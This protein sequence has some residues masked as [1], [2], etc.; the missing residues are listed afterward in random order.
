MTG[1]RAVL[2]HGTLDEGASFRGV[3]RH[4]G[5]WETTA[6]DRSGWGATPG[7]GPVDLAG[8]VADL[9]ARLPAGEPCVLVG[10]SFGA[11]LALTLAAAAPDRVRAVVAF[12]PPLPWLPWWPARAPWEEIVLDGP[13][14]PA[15]AAEALLREVLGDATWE[16]LPD[17]VRARRRAQGVRLQA[18]MRDL[19]QTAPSFDPLTLGCPLLTAAGAASL[20][21][22][23]LTSA[24][25]AELV[26]RGAYRE[27]PG[28]GH[29]AHVTHAR[30]FA[31]LLDA[32]LEV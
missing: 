13:G 2:V 5:G 4:L 25:L 19:L 12:E 29:P 32:A 10:H 11:T 3:V 22:H 18:E 9:E 28:A 31:G 15:D 20:P 30:A 23:R 24:R 7:D 6:Y 16:R 21:H 1:G 26:P 27:L 14:E 17:A 8:Q